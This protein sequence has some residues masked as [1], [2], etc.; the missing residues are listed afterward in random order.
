MFR[1][2]QVLSGYQF[3]HKVGKIMLRVQMFDLI[4]KQLFNLGFLVVN[5]GVRRTRNVICFEDACGTTKREARVRPLSLT[6]RSSSGKEDKKE[7][8]H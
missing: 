1:N 6:Q 2:C 4:S 5:D 8:L 3:F 7:T